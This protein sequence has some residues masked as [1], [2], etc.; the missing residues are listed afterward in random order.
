M[1]FFHITIGSG[2]NPGWDAAEYV[3]M[4]VYPPVHSY[5]AAASDVTPKDANSDDNNGK[6][7]N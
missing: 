3:E 2:W 7:S 5:D 4:I 6:N 1:N